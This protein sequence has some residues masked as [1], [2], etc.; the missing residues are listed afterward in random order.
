ML[1][2][3]EF[4]D[5][6][7]V[8]PSTVS[9]TLN[10]GGRISAA[11]RKRV[12]EHIEEMGYIPNVNAQ[13]LITGRANMAALDFGVNQ[14]LLSDMYFSE[15]TRGIQWAL[16]AQD[17]GLLLNASGDTLRRWVK[18]Q[19]VDAVLVVGGDADEEEKVREIATGGTPCVLISHC[20]MNPEPNFTS[21]IT[22][23]SSGAREVAQMLVDKGHRR[24][25]FLGS[26]EQDRVLEGFRAK[27]GELGVPLAE[28]RIRFA[29]PDPE[30]VPQ[31]L[32]ALFALPEPP[33]AIFA[34]TDALAAAVLR[35]ALQWGLQIPQDLSVV[36]HDDVA[37]A[38]L[39]A[40]ALTTVRLD[41]VRMG[42]LAVEALCLLL[43]NPG[44]RV[45]PRVVQSR[46]VVRDT[47]APPAKP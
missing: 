15:L 41:C 46:L 27:L 23:L 43:N 13:R 5:A 40:P 14:H 35:T 29:G 30:R 10:G 47:V 22:D 18:S 24:I 2:I 20:L 11:T 17:Y 12:M 4:A 8:S 16:K 28:E 39:T 32:E 42:E 19:A 33:T 21:V 36:G 7:G 44:L 9:R 34:R 31:E 26:Y 37:F 3:R 45:R 1:T 25:G 6:I 38:R